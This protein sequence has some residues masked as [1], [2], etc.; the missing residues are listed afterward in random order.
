[1]RPF[2]PINDYENFREK[3]VKIREKCRKIRENPGIIRVKSEEKKREN[4]RKIRENPENSRKKCGKSEKNL[5]T[6]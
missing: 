6:I 5:G 4:L 3:P 1:M 2:W